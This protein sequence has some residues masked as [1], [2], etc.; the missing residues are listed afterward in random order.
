MRKAAEIAAQRAIT[1]EKRRVR[2]RF[3]Q[4][5]GYT[6]GAEKYMREA[7]FYATKYGPTDSVAGPKRLG[8]RGAYGRSSYQGAEGAARRVSL[9]PTQ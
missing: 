3:V 5:L 9:S 6:A 8:S 2:R 4:E 1:A 7:L